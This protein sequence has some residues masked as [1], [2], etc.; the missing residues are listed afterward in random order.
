VDIHFDVRVDSWMVSGF[1][2]LGWS[3]SYRT[4]P[5]S[6][7]VKP[8]RKKSRCLKQKEQ[9]YRDIYIAL[10]WQGDMNIALRNLVP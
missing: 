1:S 6:L 4:F 7:R 3:G 8:Q 2:F 10:P 5:V 9:M